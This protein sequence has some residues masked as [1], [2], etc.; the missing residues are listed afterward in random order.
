MNTTGTTGFFTF[1][2]SAERYHL[3]H[4]PLGLPV[5][6]L[7]RRVLI[8]AF[9]KLVERRFPLATGLEDRITE[10]LFNVIEND[11][12]QSGEVRGFTAQSYDRVVRHAQ[13]TNYT[14][15]KLGKTP[16]LSFKLRNDEGEP[17]SVLSSHEALFVEC[18]PIDDSHAAGSGYCDEG[19]L[20]FVN[21]D[22]AWAMEQALMIGYA[23]QGRTIARHL[24]PA[25][26]EPT[27]RAALKVV[28]PP[29]VVELPSASSTSTCEALHVS[30][31]ERGFPW[32]DG[33][34][35]ATNIAIYHSWHR[36]E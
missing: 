18:K 35:A 3:P 20:R 28:D 22:Y 26:E 25:V 21:G 34:G 11:L 12:R 5:I 16:D 33:K 23:R 14:A 27:R 6:L 32:P 31:H 24:I 7:I 19:L 15:S 36:C 10:Q 13:V 29:R 4:P 2:V 8:R 9:E 17:C 1:G 30:N